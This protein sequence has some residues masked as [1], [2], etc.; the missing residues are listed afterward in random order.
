MISLTNVRSSCTMHSRM[1]IR[2]SLRRNSRGICV[3]HGV[4]LSR[5][6]SQQPD[7]ETWRLPCGTAP[8]RHSEMILCDV[9]RMLLRDAREMLFHDVRRMF[10]HDVRICTFAMF[11]M[12]LPNVRGMLLQEVHFSNS[13]HMQTRAIGQSQGLP[14]YWPC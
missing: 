14:H 13:G 3:T 4:S 2:L 6:S 12:F 7:F 8:S 1:I 9:R 10:P 5:R 11:E